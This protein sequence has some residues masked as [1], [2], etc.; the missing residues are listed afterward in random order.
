MMAFGFFAPGISALRGHTEA[1]AGISQNIANLTIQDCKATDTQFAE[2]VHSGDGGVFEQFSGLKID[3]RNLIEDQGTIL[4]TNR[5]FDIAIQRTGFLVTNTLHD[6]FEDSQRTRAGSLDRTIVLIRGPRSKP[7]SRIKTVIL[8][9]A[10]P[11]MARAA[12]LSARLSATWSPYALIA[13]PSAPP[14]QRQPPRQWRRTCPPG[15]RQA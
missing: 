7:S 2:I 11:A 1:F 10:G 12:S 15:Q 5:N 6:L 9:S 14:P 8:F 3:T 4:S 13:E